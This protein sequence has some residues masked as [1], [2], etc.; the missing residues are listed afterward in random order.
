[1]KELLSNIEM[2]TGNLQCEDWEEV[3]ERVNV[4]K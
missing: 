4:E 1:M 2:L 3:L